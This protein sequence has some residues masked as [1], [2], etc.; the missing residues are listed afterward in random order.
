[1]FASDDRLGWSLWEACQN[2]VEQL[3]VLVEQLGMLVK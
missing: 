1:M 2:L 3:C